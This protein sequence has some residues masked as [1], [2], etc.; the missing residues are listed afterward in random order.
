[1]LINLSTMREESGGGAHAARRFRWWWIVI[2]VIA[3][4]AIALGAIAF[5]NRPPNLPIPEAPVA[6]AAPEVDAACA[7]YAAA[8]DS[9]R[10]LGLDRDRPLLEEAWAQFEQCTEIDIEFVS[11][12]DTAQLGNA[13]AWPDV[14]LVILPSPRPLANLVERGAVVAAPEGVVINVFRGWGPDWRAYGTVNDTLYAAPLGASVQSLVWYAPAQFAARGLAVPQ[15]WD[16]LFDL[17]DDVARDGIKP[18]CGGTA[19]GSASGWA[20]SNW[21]AE[22]V[23]RMYGGALYDRWITNA[24]PFDSPQIAGSMEVLSTWMRNPE[25]VNGGFGDPATVAT[26]PTEDVG[27][28]VL[29]GDC[30]ML[31]QGAAYASAWQVLAPG[32]VIAPDGDVFAFILPEMS[33]DIAQP[34]MGEG[35]FV[36]A[37]SDDPAVQAV[38]TLLSSADFAADRAARGGWVTA[39]TEVDPD[40]FVDPLDR[41]QAEALTR[42]TFRITASDLLP[43]EVGWGAFW[44]QMAAWFADE[45]TLE[46]ALSAISAAWPLPEEE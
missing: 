32:T 24:L 26:T 44:P 36:V 25:Y 1:M 3:I 16:D 8:E 41:L 20:A 4:V 27:S 2:A 5:T 12:T 15:T 31:Q 45:V 38:Q 7:G 18:W 19:A 10:I 35:Q 37:R 17:S 39:N 13:D 42:G 34:I 29:A 23:L 30:L 9:V 22:V 11:A 33:P 40:L 28:A 43:P 46:E 21:L 6:T 14:D